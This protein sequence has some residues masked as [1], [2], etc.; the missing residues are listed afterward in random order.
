MAYVTERDAQ[1]GKQSQSGRRKWLDV[2]F[3]AFAILVFASS[4]TLAK[5]VLEQVPPITTGALRFLLASSFVLPF[6]FAKYRSRLFVGYTRKDWTTIVVIA[7]TFILLP[8]IFQ[9]VGLLYTSAALAGVI[10]GTIPIFVAILAFFFLKEKT[11]LVRW[12]GAAIALVGV[13]LISSGGNVLGLEGSSA[14]GNALQVGATIFYAIGSILLKSALRRVKPGVLV[15]MI[16]LIG[17]GMLS[18]TSVSEAG[19]WPA[20]LS[21]STLLALLLFAGLYAA[22]LFCW[23]WVLEHVSVSSLYF[24]LFLM[25]VLGIII[26]VLLLGETFTVLDVAFAFVILLGLGIAQ[27]SDIQKKN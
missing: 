18:L 9:N 10:Q 22:G 27:V 15:T 21:S 23:F 14:L 7:T 5:V 13:I 11:N 17:G 19:S 1:F 26:P 12:V 6:A 25:P 24:T 8:Q 4:Y 16:F 20:S 2:L 3:G